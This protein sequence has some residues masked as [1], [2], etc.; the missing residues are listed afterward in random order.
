[1][2]IAPRDGAHALETLLRHNRGHTGYAPI[3]GA[4]WLVAFAQH[5]TFAEAF[6]ALGDST[7]DGNPFLLELRALPVED[8]AARVRRLVA[9]QI[10]TILRRTVDPDRAIAEYGLDSL[11]VL[12]VRARIEAETG[13]RVGTTDITTVRALADHLTSVLTEDLLAEG[14]VN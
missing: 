2:A 6:R 14:S 9:E 5:S 4:P 3:A 13:V 10:G 8:R 1:M 12:E 11:G 7:S